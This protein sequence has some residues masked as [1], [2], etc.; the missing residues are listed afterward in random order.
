MSLLDSY[1]EGKFHGR[2]EPGDSDLER[3]EKT[4]HL[5]QEFRGAARRGDLDISLE[6]LT[7]RYRKTGHG[8][9]GWEAF[10]DVGNKL[11]GEEGWKRRKESG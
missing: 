10:D 4:K 2:P 11:Y 5:L 8:R 3:Q 9:K 1:G 7:N 6:E